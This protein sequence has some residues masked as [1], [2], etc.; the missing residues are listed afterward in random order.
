MAKLDQNKIYLYDSTLRDGAQT[1]TV[2]FGLIQT[3][4]RKRLLV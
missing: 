1:S 4:N 3:N 2:N